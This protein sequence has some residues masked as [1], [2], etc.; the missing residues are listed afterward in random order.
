MIVQI[1]WK[2]NSVNIRGNSNFAIFLESAGPPPGIDV[3]SM[4]IMHILQIAW[5]HSKLFRSYG[6]MDMDNGPVKAAWQ[7]QGDVV[8]CI[9]FENL[10]L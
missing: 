6:G 5:L 2:Q 8:T 10:S 1:L 3:S 9:Y 4:W 7:G